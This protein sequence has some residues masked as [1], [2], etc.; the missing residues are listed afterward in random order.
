MKVVR[1]DRQQLKSE[2]AAHKQR[3][4]FVEVELAEFQ[5]NAHAAQLALTTARQE[6]EVLH[7][8]LLATETQLGF[9]EQE[10]DHAQGELAHREQALTAAKAEI[11]TLHEESELLRKEIDVVRAERVHAESQVGTMNNEFAALTAKLSTVEEASAASAGT[12][13]ALRAETDVLRRDLGGTQSGRELMDLRSRLSQTKD[14]YKRAKARLKDLEHDAKKLAATEEKLRS[15][16]KEARKLRAEAERRAEKV[17]EQRLQKDNE[18]LRGIVA[19]QNEELERGH[20][21]LARLRKARLA[22]RILYAV[23]GIGLAAIVA[24]VV[25]IIPTLFTF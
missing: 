18:V 23:F 11:E 5:A 14:E 2:L 6:V 24:L 12:V 22:L 16:L 4:G 21:E 15:E 7:E 25:R 17:G 13:V 1:A 10:R 8:R 9:R 3:L 20:T 19:R